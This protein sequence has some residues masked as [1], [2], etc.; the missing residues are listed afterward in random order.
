MFHGETINKKS[1]GQ[2]GED[3]TASHLASKGWKIIEKNVR[4][5]FGEIDILAKTADGR[6][7]FV[8]VKTISKGYADYSGMTPED[9][10]SREKLG[11]MKKMAEW[12]A[13]KHPELIGDGGWQIDLAA[14][15]LSDGKAGNS[16]IKLYSNIA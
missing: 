11:K 8:E 2:L 7:H 1:V 6:L 5:K 13:N 4:E 3:L 16:E 14:I 15:S 9:N 10:L 12:Y